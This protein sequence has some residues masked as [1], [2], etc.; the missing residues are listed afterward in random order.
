VRL[1]EAIESFLD[2]RKRLGFGCVKTHRW[3]LRTLLLSV[4]RRRREKVRDASDGGEPDDIAAAQLS[5]EDLDA[6]VR[7]CQKRRYA[8]ASV[9]HVVQIT[10]TFCQWL[11]RRGIVLVDPS[12]TLVA[13]RP[14][15]HVGFVPSP[16]Q[17]RHLLHVASPDEVLRRE[18]LF[19]D[20]DTIRPSLRTRYALR[21]ERVLS[22]AIRDHAIIEVLYG[23]GLR[24]S[25]LRNLDTRDLSLGE[26]TLF[27][28]SGKGKKD[29]VVPLTRASV[30]AL[31]RY[32]HEARPVLL[33]QR[34]ATVMWRRRGCR[35][36]T[37][38]FLTITASRLP[39]AWREHVL[40]PLAYRAG[41]RKGFTPH[42]LRHACAL[43]LLDA[44]AGVVAIGRL[45][46][47]S[48]LQATEIYLNLTTAQLEKA[49][50]KAHPREKERKRTSRSG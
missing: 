26:R 50:M 42:R 11:F 15:I 31:S 9:F 41:L 40:R 32:L 35:Q 33:S 28:R 12:L 47:H 3:E 14:R 36:P 1:D 20:P 18:Q 46:G 2:E 44:G 43:H 13:R 10:R 37:A 23:S 22:E 24:F 34:T 49:L 6:L 45:L 7:E 25:E 17:V 38:L 48:S 29:R 30:K 5:R 21:R 4:V 27:I 39:Q 8:P 16:E 19:D